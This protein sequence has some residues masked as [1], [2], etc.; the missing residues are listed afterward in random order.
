MEYAVQAN[1]VSKTLVKTDAQT[2]ELQKLDFKPVFL[3]SQKRASC[4]TS[5]D[6]L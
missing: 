3:H 2:L 4:N 5:V 6:I 1:K